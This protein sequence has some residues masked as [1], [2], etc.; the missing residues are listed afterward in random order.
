MTLIDLG[1]HGDSE[2]QP[3]LVDFAVNVAAIDNTTRK[4]LADGKRSIS[5]GFWFALGHSTIVLALGALIAVGAKAVSTLSGAN[6][7]THQ[8]LGVIGTSVSGLF[9]YLIG[10]LN[11]LALVVIVRVYRRAKTEGYDA[12][13]LDAALDD[14]GFITHLLRPLM[15]SITHPAQMY[16]I[17]LLFGWAST[18]PR[19]SPCSC[20]PEP[21]RPM[22]SRRAK[23]SQA[24]ALRSKIVLACA[25][26]V[27][28]NM[29]A[30]G[31]GCACRA[32]EATYDLV[33]N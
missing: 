31:L 5:V 11:L 27:D 16:P 14:R 24:L 1:H 12:H 25:E 22:V 23:S 2:V 15:R 13:A 4:L 6:S 7:A 21:V 9:R 17:G 18:P 32:S 29:V 10:I 26:G 30:V 8:M 19:R 3:G 20:L 33:R 28:N